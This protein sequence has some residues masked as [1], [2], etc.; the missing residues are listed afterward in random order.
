MVKVIKY[1]LRREFGVHVAGG[2]ILEIVDGLFS[3][4]VT[5]KAQARVLGTIVGKGTVIGD[6]N[7]HVG[8]DRFLMAV[9]DADQFDQHEVLFVAVFVIPVVC[10][11][12]DKDQLIAGEDVAVAVIDDS[13]RARKTHR[14]FGFLGD[15]LLL[16]GRALDDLQMVEPHPQN[17]KKQKYNKTQNE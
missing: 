2:I 8:A 7:R 13:S 9:E 4:H 10:D 14:P 17:S 1:P 12:D 5:Q 16:L 11:V 3:I 6:K 15:I